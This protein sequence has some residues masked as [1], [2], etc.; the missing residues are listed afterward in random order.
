[1]EIAFI[2]FIKWVFSIIHWTNAYTNKQLFIIDLIFTDEQNFSGNTGVHASL[3]QVVHSSFN[4]KYLL[5]HP[6]TPQ[7]KINK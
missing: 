4:L 3:H 5:P 6:P 7:K 2:Y 1:M